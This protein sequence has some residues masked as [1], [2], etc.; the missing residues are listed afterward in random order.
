MCGFLVSHYIINP[1]Y[2]IV[3][4]ELGGMS[5]KGNGHVGRSKLLCEKGS[6]PKKVASNQDK[7]FTLS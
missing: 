3:A 2:F 5:Q 6:A 4:D 1:D 7:H